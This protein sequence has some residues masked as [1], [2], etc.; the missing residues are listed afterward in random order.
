MPLSFPE[1]LFQITA[2]KFSIDDVD[3][4]SA[5]TGRGLYL[6]NHAGAACSL[7]SSKCCNLLSQLINFIFFN[8]FKTDETIFTSC[9]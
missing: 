8:M 3:D 9:A 6:S 1:L 2:S 4:A 5:T 7:R